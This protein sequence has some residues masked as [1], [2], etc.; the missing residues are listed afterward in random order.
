MLLQIVL[1]CSLYDWYSIVYIDIYLTHIFFIHSDV[2]EHIGCFHVLANIIALFTFGCF[3]DSYANG[4]WG[5]GKEVCK[6][7][8]LRQFSGVCQLTYVPILHWCLDQD[9]SAEQRMGSREFEYFKQSNCPR[10]VIKISIN[11]WSMY[12]QWGNG[13]TEWCGKWRWL[14]QPEWLCIL[15]GVCHLLFEHLQTTSSLPVSFRSKILSYCDLSHNF[16]EMHLA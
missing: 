4:R 12:I 9:L 6:S 10:S 2:D 3:S 15:S 8:M 5:W 11:W 14:T 7:K 16:H 13:G 1:F